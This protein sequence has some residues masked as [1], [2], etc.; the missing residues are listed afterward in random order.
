MNS[1]L[2]RALL[3]RG[4]LAGIV[5]GLL[6]FGF[7]YFIGE[8]PL[9]GALVYEAAHTTE[10]GEELVGRAM[11]ATTGLATGVLIFG[12]AVGGIAALAFSVLLG[13]IGRFSPRATAALVSLAAFVTV[14]L[15]PFLKYP[16]NPP[17]TSDPDT[18]NQ[19][20]VM[21]FLMIALSVLLGSGAVLL[22]RRLAPRWGNWNASVI[23][24]AAFVAA[25]TMAVVFLPAI[26]E[27]PKDFPAIGLWQ[28][29]LA[30]LGI[31]AVLWAGFGL[32]FGYLADRVLA[33]RTATVAGAVPGGT[34]VPA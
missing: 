3:V 17:A 29:R 25:V 11:Q 10:H 15:V 22:G 28:F 6:A 20:T 2:V 9:E 19:R 5:A 7:A 12:V 16:A 34:S 31:Q 13:R 23:A 18:L 8:P 27:T 4:M 30:A 21:Y 1:T 32:V 24:G 26:Q 14:C 33:P